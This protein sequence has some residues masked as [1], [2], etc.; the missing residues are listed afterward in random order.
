MYPESIA[1][2][3]VAVGRFPWNGEAPASKVQLQLHL[4]VLFLDLVLEV[5]YN[6]IP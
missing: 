4:E 5:E 2:T 1:R 3:R 6:T